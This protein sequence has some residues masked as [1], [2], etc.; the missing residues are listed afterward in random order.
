MNIKKEKLI[1]EGKAKILYETNYPDKCIIYFK[2]DATAFDGAKKSTILNK[3]I[4]NN[5]VSSWIFSYL[6]HHGIENHF[7][8]KLSDRE[9]LVQKVSIIPVE[10]V[11]RNKATGS[12]VRRLGLKNGMPFHPPLMEYFYK[13]DELHDPLVSES[14]VTYFKWATPEEFD[15]MQDIALKVNDL[16]RVVFSEIGLDLIDFKLEFGLTHHCELLLADEFTQDGCRLWDKKTGES[17]DKDRFR[18]DL[19]KVEETYQEVYN[20]LEKFFKGKNF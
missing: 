19:G 10:V 16:L 4:I 3:G 6:S 5:N 15:L 17:M 11:V 18:H 8:E 13:S 2:D 14:H 1:Y 20:R 7:V 12:I 9:M